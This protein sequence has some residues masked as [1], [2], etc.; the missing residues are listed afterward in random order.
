MTQMLAQLFS[1]TYT[2][3]ILKFCDGNHNILDISKA[4]GLT[5]KS[6]FLRIKKLEDAGIVTVE[7]MDKVGAGSKIKIADTYKKDVK[8]RT[9]IYE[10]EEQHVINASKDKNKLQIIID[11]LTML[12]KK[13]F[14]DREEMREALK[15]AT[16]EKLADQII[17]TSHL[18]NSG[19][20]KER[21]EITKKGIKFL[22]LHKG[23]PEENKGKSG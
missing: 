1:K 5:Y 20:I 9:L 7:S 4:I 16:T 8:I 15:S 3:D 21:Q 6:T 13:R 18:L 14:I 11:L 17:L 23:S 10:S 2:L 12:K 22:E 19:Y